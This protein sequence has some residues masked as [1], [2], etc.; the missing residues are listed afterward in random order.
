MNIGSLLLEIEYFIGVIDFSTRDLL[1][2][3]DKRRS[4]VELTIIRLFI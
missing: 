3:N 2:R 1:G 4:L